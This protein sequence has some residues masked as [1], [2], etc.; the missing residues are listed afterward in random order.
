MERQAYR[1]NQVD[2]GV[3]VDIQRLAQ[4]HKVVVDKSQVFEDEKHKTCRDDA[5]HQKPLLKFMIVS[6]FLH[7]NTC[8]IIDDYRDEKYQDVFRDEPHIERAAGDEEHH[9]A[10]PVWQQVE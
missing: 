2:G 10:E 3:E 5:Y 9:P 1:Q 8:R 4:R 6:V 7:Q